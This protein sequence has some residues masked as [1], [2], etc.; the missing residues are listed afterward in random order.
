MNQQRLAATA[1]AA[2]LS[3][4]TFA[5]VKASDSRQPELAAASAES[6]KL[7]RTIKWNPG[8][9]MASYKVLYP[10]NTLADVQGELNDLR[11]Q[12]AIVGYRVLIAWSALEDD[13]GKYT[14][15]VLDDIFNHLKAAYGKPKHMVVVVVP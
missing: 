6:G 4:V 13:E 2:S 10:D 8:H 9:Y 14:F 12:D 1:L 3:L 5:E 11:N 15:A 7:A